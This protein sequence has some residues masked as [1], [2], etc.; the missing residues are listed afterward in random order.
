[1]HVHCH[2]GN[3]GSI[4]IILVAAVSRTSETFTAKDGDL[5]IAYIFCSLISGSIAIFSVGNYLLKRRDAHSDTIDL[6]ADKQLKHVCLAQQHG[7][8]L[9]SCHSRSPGG[10]GNVLQ[11]IHRVDIDNKQCGGPGPAGIQVSRECHT[12]EPAFS[13]GL[14]WEQTIVSQET[15]PTSELVVQARNAES[16][17]SVEQG[18]APGRMAMLETMLCRGASSTHEGSMATPASV[19]TRQDGSGSNP[20]CVTESETFRKVTKGLGR[21]ASD[22]MNGLQHGQSVDALSR[23]GAL[24]VGPRLVSRKMCVQRQLA[25]LLLLCSAPKTKFQ[26]KVHYRDPECRVHLWLGCLAV[27]NK[28]GAYLLSQRSRLPQMLCQSAIKCMRHA[29]LEMYDEPK[30]Q[31]LP[32]PLI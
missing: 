3:L 25:L 14:N 31:E 15:S 30:A 11:A 4:P 6:Q 21:P 12:R 8:D 22:A 24:A 7:S 26:H 20:L 17:T 18:T 23:V 2:A 19:H 9:N 27:R 29:H 5:G 32:R 1:M 13:A 16:G 28:M 10:S